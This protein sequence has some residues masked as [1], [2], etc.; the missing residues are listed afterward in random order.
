MHG[1][2]FIVLWLEMIINNIVFTKRHLLLA[3]FLGLIF[4][5]EIILYFLFLDQPIYPGM[6]ITTYICYILLAG[7]YVVSI[8]HFSVGY[9][10]S[11]KIKLPR[12]KGI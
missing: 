1:G 8:G 12:I 9:Y 3:V 11:N 6:D 2:I 7:C 5:V 4:V 10:F